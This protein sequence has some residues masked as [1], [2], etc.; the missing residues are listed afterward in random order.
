M[1]VDNKLQ[2]EMSDTSISSSHPNKMIITGCICTVGELSAHAPCG[3]GG[4]QVVIMQQAAQDNVKSFEGTPVNCIFSDWFPED[5]LTGHDERQT[6][7][8]IT[9]AWIDGNK[10]MAEVVV[11]KQNYPDIA[12]MILNAQEALGFSIEANI[13]SYHNEG[14]N[15]EIIDGFTGTGCAILWKKCAAFGE[16]TYI[17]ELA[18]SIYKKKGKGD[19]D[20]TQEEMKQLSEM[21]AKA[22]DEKVQGLGID[23]IKASIK[24]LKDAKADDSVKD[25]LNKITASMQDM[26]KDKV[27]ADAKIDE[28]KATIDSWKNIPTPKS[29]Q[30]NDD[31][32]TKFD[33]IKSEIEKIDASKDMTSYE[34]MKAKAA[35]LLK[36]E[37]EG[38]DIS[39]SY[40]SL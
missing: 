36:A 1:A 3:S 10:I 31:I 19:V 15:I 25:E 20:M 6:I 24:D 39:G 8:N 16:A 4:R 28:L 33:K 26:V 34:K 35:I 27:K 22:V 21:I 38:V 40:K 30:G 14:E 29:A 9:S 12:F 11:W 32:D 23:E 13:N 17:K 7:G 5:C 2:F 18:A 37:K